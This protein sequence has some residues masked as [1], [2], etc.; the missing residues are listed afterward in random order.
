[1]IFK[2][3]DELPAIFLCLVQPKLVRTVKVCKTD[4]LAF[5]TRLI[6]EDVDPLR[7]IFM[8]GLLNSADIL[9]ALPV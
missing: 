6:S 4:C 3:I 2:C 5:S 1:M 8:S 9:H 7:P